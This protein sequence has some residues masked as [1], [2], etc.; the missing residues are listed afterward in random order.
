M[1]KPHSEILGSQGGYYKDANLLCCCGHD[2]Q[3]EKKKHL[4]NVDKLVA[5][6]T[7]QHYGRQ[8]QRFPP[9]KVNITFHVFKTFYEVIRVIN[10]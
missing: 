8:P 1:Q 3:D 6:Y 10:N 9:L 7:A 4:R 2:L 5:D